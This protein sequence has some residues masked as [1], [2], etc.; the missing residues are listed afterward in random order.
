MIEMK[1]ILNKLSKQFPKSIAKRYDDYVGIMVGKMPGKVQ[2]IL[3]C[4]DL[5]ESIFEQVK[6]YNPDV[7]L[8]HHPFIYGPKAKILKSD[9]IKRK[10]VSNL[11][12]MNIAVYSYHTNFDA[13]KGGM[14]DALL[15]KLGLKNI[16]APT[17][18][19]AMRIGYLDEPMDINK[20]AKYVKKQFNVE[21]GLLINKGKETVSKIGIIGGGGSKYF[22]IAKDEGCD[23]YISGD[24]THRTRRNVI[25]SGYNYLDVPH[26]IEK[27]FM[28]TMK[29]ILLS[30]D[31]TLDILIVDHEK[32]ATVI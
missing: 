23:L 16:Y 11:E 6:Q 30:I 32:E 12:K 1:T 5:D 26:E 15:E 22:T 8:T 10:L 29:N 4:L 20:F 9:E 18:E 17:L 31:S 21:Y 14:N 25:L 24:I 3:L 27:I 7:I 28:P 13:G 2:K 19:P